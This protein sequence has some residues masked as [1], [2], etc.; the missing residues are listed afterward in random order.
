[1]FSTKICCNKKKILSNY[2]GL[3]GRPIPIW[4]KFECRVEF[5]KKTVWSGGVREKIRH[6][7]V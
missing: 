7:Y 2:H 4:G 5:V 6:F 1:M 3:E